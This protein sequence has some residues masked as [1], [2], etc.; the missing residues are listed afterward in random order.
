MP[1][2]NWL[3]AWV[4]INAKH[5]VHPDFAEKISD[6]KASSSKA[7]TARISEDSSTASSSG[8]IKQRSISKRSRGKGLQRTLSA[9]DLI[10]EA[11]ATSSSGS[12]SKRDLLS[13]A[14]RGQTMASSRH[15]QD[16]DTLSTA[17]SSIDMLLPD[18]SHGATFLD[19][20]SF[21]PKPDQKHVLQGRSAISVNSK[22]MLEPRPTLT[23]Q[24][25]APPPAPQTLPMTAFAGMLLPHPFFANQQV[26]HQCSSYSSQL[27]R[28]HDDLEYMR[29]LTLQREA[30]ERVAVARKHVPSHQQIMPSV[31]SKQLAEVTMRQRKQVEQLMKERF[32]WQQDMHFKLSKFANLCKDL[33]EESAA[34]KSEA[35]SLKKELHT[36]TEERNAMSED[37]FRLR[38]V[39]QLY[40]Q[41]QLELE[42]MRKRVVA[43]ES[44]AMTEHARAIQSRDKT[45]D[46]LTCKL[47]RV[48]SEL[49]SSRLQATQRRVIFPDARR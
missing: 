18:S 17:K 7:S 15:D 44:T 27:E 12:F 30:E 48:L 20:I 41:Q 37:L 35:L 5:G 24:S 49:E 39:E 13:D 16:A 9:S 6:Y 1:T 45:I 33:N 32:R 46:D 34:R 40:V 2:P 22:T 11:A 10:R 43:Y 36:V 3:T 31:A 28:L 42:E 23:R 4:K 26:C 47:D 38:A 8:A 14:N 19:E 25:Y 21:T 29:K